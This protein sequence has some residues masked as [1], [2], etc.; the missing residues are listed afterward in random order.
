MNRRLAF[1]FLATACVVLLPLRSPAPL[2]Y[3]P[4]EGWT[5]EPVGGE[6]KWRRTRAKDQMEVAQAAFD[7]R[8]YSVA[9]KAARHLVKTWPLSDYAPRAQ[10]LVGR[11]YEAKHNDEKAFKHYQKI[12]EQYPKSENVKEVLQRQ[13]EIAG[14]FLAGQ[15]FKLG[16]YIPWFPSMDKTA[17][18]FD[19]IVKS[20]PY[21]DVAPH[22]QLRIGAAR[23]KQSHYPEAVKAY[24]TAA[25]RYHDRPQIAAD[26]VYRA[27][28][29]YQKQAKS[30]EYDQSMAGQ[31]I[32]Q[33][34]DFVTLYP[35]DRR[36]PEAQKIMTSLKVEQARGNFETAKYYEKRRKWNGALVYYNEV[37]L[38]DPNS[39]LA[40]EARKRIDA[41]KQHTLTARK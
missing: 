28:V 37:V 10:Y 30:A 13:Y 32:A 19:K 4:G 18:M 26:A 3:T 8:D 33:F 11:C 22:A 40:T 5:Y 17:E 21:S 41:I 29:A 20:G 39:P 35:D 25:D 12:L 1:L 36:V 6:G 9:R 14:R 34:T 31:A 7:K 15:W 2:V 27:G 38:R 23:E 16:G 24:E